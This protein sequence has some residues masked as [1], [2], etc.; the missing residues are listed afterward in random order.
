MKTCYPT[1]MDDESYD[2]PK[3]WPK[4]G[5]LTPNGWSRRMVVETAI[6]LSKQDGT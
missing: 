6:D 4:L 2:Y 5:Q 3:P 1:K